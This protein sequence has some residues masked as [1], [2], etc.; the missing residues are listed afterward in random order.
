MAVTMLKYSGMG[1]F[2]MGSVVSQK[3]Q[4]SWMPIYFLVSMGTLQS[5]SFA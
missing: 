4:V 5:F 2:Q 1:H 3:Y